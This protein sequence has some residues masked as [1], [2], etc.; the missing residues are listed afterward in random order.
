MIPGFR[1]PGHLSAESFDDEDLEAQAVA[2]HIVDLLA[3]GLPPD[4]VLPGESLEIHPAQICLLG[5]ARYNLTPLVAE[6]ESR[7]IPFQFNN[8]EVNIFESSLFRFSYFAMRVLANPRDLLSRENMLGEWQDASVEVDNVNSIR[9]LSSEDLF[10]LIGQN[11]QSPIQDAARIFSLTSKD[12]ADPKTL[13]DR[14]RAL[15]KNL[16]PDD[17]SLRAL[18]LIDAETLRDRWQNCEKRFSDQGDASLSDFL[19]E[20]SLAGR[21]VLD[22]DGIQLLTVHAAKGLEYKA[23]FV[24]GMNEGS[25]PDFRSSK[26]PEGIEDERRNAYVAI[27]RAARMLVLSRPRTR[28]M[29][30]GDWKTQDPSRFLAEMSVSVTDS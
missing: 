27:T 26:S 4:S 17:E 16:V 2:D 25:F 10:K 29:P 7:N 18:Y 23:V 13:V 15:A 30:W 14:L 19:G 22:G 8:G 3:N 12:V 9:D 20:I 21:N 5:R 28:L 1:A 6:L 11:A 24:V